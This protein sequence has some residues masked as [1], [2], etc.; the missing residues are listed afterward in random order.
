MSHTMTLVSS[1]PDA[2]LDESLLHAREDTRPWWNTR[3]VC[4]TCL[5]AESHIT[6]FL[7]PSP[8]ASILPHGEYATLDTTLW[9][10]LRTGPGVSL[11]PERVKMWMPLSSPPTATSAPVGETETP[12]AANTMEVEEATFHPAPPWPLRTRTALLVATRSV[13]PSGCRAMPEGC[14]PRG[15]D[16][17]VKDMSGREDTRRVSSRASEMSLP[18]TMA[19]STIALVWPLPWRESAAAWPRVNLLTIPS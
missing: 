12:R 2:S 16:S 5:E 8:E 3:P 18:C 6:T 19:R 9:W 4:E 15:R 14:P 13:L 7:V 1:E 10:W 11:S 17:G